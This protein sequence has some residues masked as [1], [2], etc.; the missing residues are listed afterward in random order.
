MALT[1]NT[2]HPLFGNL[3]SFIC[4]EG[5]V[6]KDLVQTGRTF[7]PHAAVTYGTNGYGEFFKTAQVSSNAQGV[8]FTPV[9]ETCDPAQKT[10]LVIVTDHVNLGAALSIRAT[11][12]VS[13]GTFWTGSAV[14]SKN[15]HASWATTNGTVTNPTM[16]G[17]TR[18]GETSSGLVQNGTLT[19]QGQLYY[20]GAR[21][22]GYIG[23]DPTGGFGG[24]LVASYNYIIEFDVAL[25]AT[26]VSDIYSSLG[27]S[28]AISLLSSAPSGSSASFSVT[29]DD[30]VFSGNASVLGVPASAIFALVTD[31]VV[32]SGG[33]SVAAFA[34]ATFSITT[35]DSVFSGGAVVATSG[36]LVSDVLINNTGTVLASQAVYWSWLPSGRIGSLS[37]VTEVDG[38]GTTSVDGVLTVT[39]L[40]AG[41]GILLIAKRNTSAA[42]DHVYYQAGTVA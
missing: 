41:A 34:S 2:S 10:I 14:V 4:V 40:S 15:R 26:Q 13:P 8:A 9:M 36:T 30:V 7:T 37:S 27:A 33:A 18:T 20:N 39:G 22:S 1:L 11:G 35:E 6:I 16:I 32:F 21:P 5:G 17:F 29:T 28:G 31:N 38:T 23:G 19:A 25:D 24:C 12:G 3:K 42:D